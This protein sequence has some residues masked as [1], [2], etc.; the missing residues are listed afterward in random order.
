MGN[1]VVEEYKKDSVAIEPIDIL[2]MNPVTSNIARNKANEALSKI[3]LKNND[4][5]GSKYNIG[6]GTKQFINGSAWWIFE[7]EFRD[8]LSW[9]KD[10]QI[11]GYVKVSAEN[12]LSKAEVV[13]KDVS[14]KEI[15]EIY[16]ESAKFANKA[17]R[18][19]ATHGYMSK[20]ITNR[21]FVI[22][23]EWKPYYLYSV[24]E[25]TIGFGG[26]VFKG[27][28]LLDVQTGKIEYFDREQQ[29][30]WIDSSI[31]LSILEQNVKMWGK[32]MYEKNWWE[33]RR[34]KTKTQQ[35]NYDATNGGTGKVLWSL[36][37][38]E[39]GKSNYFATMTS[40]NAKDE[41]ITGFTISN[42]QTGITRW[43]KTPG[44]TQDVA[45]NIAIG[46]WASDKSFEPSRDIMIHNI[47]DHLTYFIPV[48]AK[49]ELQG[50]SLVSIEN[51][52][53]NG[54]GRTIAEALS[55]YRSSMAKA[56]AGDI[57]NLSETSSS[58]E[59]S[60]SIERVGFI[61]T[62]NQTQIYN[63]KIVG[64][65]KS[66]RIFY[67]EAFPETLYMKEGDNVKITYRETG[68]KIED[69]DSFDLVD[70]NL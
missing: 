27:I 48:E 14:G 19:L 25:N 56:Q 60:G 41:A 5:A 12:I 11:P 44:V 37:F 46:H 22:D 47:Y 32:Y 16:L 33:A 26:E 64:I 61:T 43:Y 69:C 21:S 30:S 35:P 50:I 53:I 51:K 8:R 54:K 65:N 7:I 59:L 55:S 15:H 70:L 2:K 28:A 34:N 67:T 58:K 42:G 40:T 29:P 3:Q 45:I 68:N 63:F 36:S 13:Q 4:I 62:S 39:N 52:S 10:K 57:T 1:V 18:Y 6:S 9:K 49:N 38:D 17:T 31:P 24:V 66:F 20:N 23:E